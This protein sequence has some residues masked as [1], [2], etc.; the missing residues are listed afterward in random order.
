[1]SVLRRAYVEVEPDV[2]GFDSSLQ[3]KLRRADPGGKAGKQV[4][5]Q[6]NRALKQFN[7]DPIDVKADPRLA[8]AGIAVAEQRL[9]QLAGESATVEVKIRTEQALGQL[10]RFRKQLGDVGAQAGP[11]AAL[12]FSASLSQRLGPLIA[13]LPISGPM[14]G[15]LAAAAAVSA[16]LIGA[17]IAGGIIGGVGVGGVIG[18]FA[19]ASK[20]ARVEAAMKGLSERLQGRL[21]AAAG[22]FVRPIQD[23]IKTIERS[24]NT[25]DFSGIFLQASQFVKPLSQA[26]GFA[27]ERMGAGVELVIRKAGPVIDVIS[28]GIAN[29]GDAVGDIFKDLSDNGVEAAVALNQAFQLVE[30]TLRLIG[31]VINGLTEAYGF[32]AKIGAFGREAQ[33]EYLRLAG[34]AKIA[35][36][37]QRGTAASIQ[38]STTA[39]AAQKAG[40]TALAAQQKALTQAQQAYNTSLDQMNP[41]AAAATQLV[42]GLRKAAEG[43]FGAAINA[44]EANEAYAASFDSLSDSVQTNGRTLNI[45]TSAGR[46]NRD[47]LQALLAANNEMYYANIATGDTTD[48]ATRKHAARTEQVR[49]EA[50]QLGLNKAET[51]KLIN[52]YG[53]IPGRKATD[54]VVEGL[55]Q[56]MIELRRVYLAQRAL[57]EGKTIDQVRYQGTAAMRSL[58]YTGGYTGDGGKYE[59]KGIVHGGEYVIKKE[60]TSKIQ[61]QA[62]GFLEELNATG[63]VGGYAAG[64]FVAP[65]ETRRR[66]PMRVDV[67]DAYVMPRALAL[68]KVAPA[69]GDWPSSP[70]AQRGDSGVWRKVLQLIRSGPDQG[71]FG[72]AYRPGDPKWHGSGRAVDWMG[73]NMDALASYLAAKRPLELIHRTRRRD[74]A[75]TRGRNKGS[76][77]NALMEAHRNHIHIA[78]AGGGVI[79][80]PVFGVG[81]SGRSYSFG[82]RGR[83]ETVTPGVHTPA[84]GGAL[85]FHF[86]GPVASKQAAQDMVLGAYNQLVRERKIR[87]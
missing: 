50:R 58:L 83:P 54:L 75:Y 55:N 14:A 76:F 66:I 51:D 71:S 31:G 77:N 18:G 47:S 9:R 5:G 87:T 4:G 56:I 39:L 21:N 27:L 20:D 40:Q 61:R 41:K 84:A 30:G 33:L 63:Q 3:E 1:V 67:G 16:P 38:Q 72:N 10:G 78:M 24:L 29:L 22:N 81:A 49:K 69:F 44:S 28:N 17:T 23:G 2:T 73:Y 13:K 8:L 52:T 74:Y 36:E 65:V 57:A 82:E 34:N 86:H 46:A 48:R 62:P 59:P 19:V 25:I 70:G 43:Q 53:R 35:Q 6:L 37:A 11:D 80:E 60:S 15:A 26:V 79:R 32:L 68:S 12:G 85:H 42:S 64:G 7:L 45:N